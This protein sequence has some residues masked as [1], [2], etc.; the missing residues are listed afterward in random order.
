M[1]LMRGINL[2]M[3]AEKMIG[4]SGAEM[5]VRYTLVIGEPELL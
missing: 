5:K 1:N 2:K 4:A 3:V